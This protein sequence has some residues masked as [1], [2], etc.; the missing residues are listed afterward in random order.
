MAAVVAVAAA[1]AASLMA[2]AAAWQKRDFRGSGSVLG[3]AAAA[4]Q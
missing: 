1:A 3:S 4:W 2:E